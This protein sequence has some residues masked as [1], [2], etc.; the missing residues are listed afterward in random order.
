M[1]AGLISNVITIMFAQAGVEDNTDLMRC[2]ILAMEIER[3]EHTIKSIKQTSAYLGCN[4]DVPMTDEFLQSL[5]DKK[6]EL[7]DFY[8]ESKLNSLESQTYEG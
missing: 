2:N 1:K 6:Q 7:I 3:N 4:Y 5:L 8:N